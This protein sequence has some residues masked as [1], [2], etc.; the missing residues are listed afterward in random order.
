MAYKILVVDDEEEM[1][2]AVAQTLEFIL[3]KNNVQIDEGENVAYLKEM[4]LNGEYNLTLTDNNM[5]DG[6]AMDALEELDRHSAIGGEEERRGG[7]KLPLI[8]MSE[9]G[10][11]D[12]LDLAE[13]VARL[14]NFDATYV[15]KPFGVRELTEALKHYGLVQ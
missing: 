4:M 1:R 9:R 8:V 13:R 11:Q 14:K 2:N 6:N 15:R 12:A 10:G 5:P 7:S 3:K